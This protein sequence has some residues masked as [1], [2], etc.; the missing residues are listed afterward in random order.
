LGT[1]SYEKVADAG[2]APVWLSDGRRLLYATPE[3]SLA[4]LDI[5]SRVSR[6]LL[7][8]GTL[9][10]AFPQCCSVSKDERWISFQ[11]DTAEGDV[12]LMTLE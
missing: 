4:L 11:H 2:V 7:P 5:P 12:W 3:G 10:Q 9:T 1:E 6:E 8:R